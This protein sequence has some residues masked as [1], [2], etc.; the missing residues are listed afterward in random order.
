MHIHAQ[1]SASYVTFTS[2]LAAAA[3]AEPPA[4]QIK[5][6]ATG[7]GNSNGA[8]SGGARDGHGQTGPATAGEAARLS[9]GHAD[10]ADK[11]KAQAEQA[12]AQADQQQIETLERR[13]AKV[14]QH[15]QA[16]L[17][18]ASGLARGGASF[19][20]TRGPDGRLYAVG[21]EVNIDTSPVAG[22][23]QATLAKAEQIQRAA[24]APASPS[25]QD[26][27]VAARAQ[28][29]ALEARAEL[30]AERIEHAEPQGAHETDAE[31][32][33]AQGSSAERDN[34]SQTAKNLRELQNSYLAPEVNGTEES[35][36]PGLDFLVA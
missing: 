7:S 30:A 24:L 3:P 15:E 23:P 16:H 9:P 2:H 33:A 6:T 10:Q 11:A 19:E 20:Q 5:A 35:H 4:D 22:D 36:E 8:G 21:G 29:M 12:K 14:R 27:A 28:A 26:R 25:G 18:S 34:R 1:S 31:L 17:A 13:D 32:E